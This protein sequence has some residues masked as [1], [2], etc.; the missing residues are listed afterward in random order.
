[1]VIA[2]LGDLEARSL[3]KMRMT[4]KVYQNLLVCE[5]LQGPFFISVTMKTTVGFWHLPDMPLSPIDKI[6]TMIGDHS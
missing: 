5:D 4:H 3:L 6:I 2:M 1:M